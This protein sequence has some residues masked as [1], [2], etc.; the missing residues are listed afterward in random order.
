MELL[1]FPH[2]LTSVQPPPNT[3][4]VA[5][6]NFEQPSPAPSL[7][8]LRAANVTN[9]LPSIAQPPFN[10]RSL[11]RAATVP[12]RQLC[13]TALPSAA[14][15]LFRR[16]ALPSKIIPWNF[17]LLMFAWKLAQYVSAPPRL[18]Q[19]TVHDRFRL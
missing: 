11:H 15:A 17:P 19:H 16:V 4:A 1:L 7:P 18:S 6:S 5:A 12:P 2:S 10:R 8:F 3:V 9:F 13:S 14:S